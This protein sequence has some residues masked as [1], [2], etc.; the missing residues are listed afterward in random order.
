LFSL[1][2]HEEQQQQQQQ[3]KKLEEPQRRPPTFRKLTEKRKSQKGEYVV[4]LFDY[5][6][7]EDNEISFKKGGMHNHICV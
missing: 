3:T 1:C 2:I 6:A 7:Q 5:E 4:A